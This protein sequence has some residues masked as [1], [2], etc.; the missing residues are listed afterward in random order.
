MLSAGKE[1]SKLRRGAFG[2]HHRKKRFEKG[3]G[4]EGGEVA[5]ITEN[6][7]GGC[8]LGRKKARTS[9]EGSL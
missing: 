7:P 6:V 9:L 8:L 4:P 1:K 2:G 5:F 3:G